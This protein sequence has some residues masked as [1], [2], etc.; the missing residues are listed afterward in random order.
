MGEGKEP[1]TMKGGAFG[2]R[3][4]Q[5]APPQQKGQVKA[6]MKGMDAALEEYRIFKSAG[7]L[8]VWR[9]RWKG[10]LKPT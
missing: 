1:R 5:I 2:E 9:A 8:D 6:N 7:M 10:V 3:L 4:H